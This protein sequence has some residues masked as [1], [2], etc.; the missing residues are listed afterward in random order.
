MVGKKQFTSAAEHSGSFIRTFASQY[1]CRGWR[2]P[3]GRFARLRHPSTSSTDVDS[4]CPRTAS[5]APENHLPQHKGP[6]QSSPLSQLP[7]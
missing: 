7:I 4:T 2:W 3:D 6:E 1:P 5:T